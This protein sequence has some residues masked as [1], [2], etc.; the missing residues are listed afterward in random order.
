MLRHWAQ[1]EIRSPNPGGG[2]SPADGWP[3]GWQPPCLRLLISP[4]SARAI[5]LSKKIVHVWPK[6]RR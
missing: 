1:G 5:P 3:V 6:T 4:V 2:G